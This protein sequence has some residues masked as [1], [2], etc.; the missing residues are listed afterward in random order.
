MM[1]PAENRRNSRI[2]HSFRRPG[3][4]ANHPHEPSR[5]RNLAALLQSDHGQRFVSTPEIGAATGAF[6]PGGTVQAA[7]EPTRRGGG[8]ALVQFGE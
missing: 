2:E 1:P 5:L 3:R 8:S 7:A 4:F 6:L